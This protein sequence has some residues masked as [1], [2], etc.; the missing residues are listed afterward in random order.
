[1]DGTTKKL[2][3][4]S[5][6]KSQIFDGH[7]KRENNHDNTVEDFDIPFLSENMKTKIP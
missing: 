5:N 6:L 7:R 4:W 2:D 1:M 3:G